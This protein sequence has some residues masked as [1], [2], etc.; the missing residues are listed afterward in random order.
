MCVCVYHLCLTL[1][2]SLSRSHITL[3]LD[4]APLSK[5]WCCVRKFIYFILAPFSIPCSILIVARRFLRFSFN[6]V[7]LSLFLSHS[8]FVSVCNPFCEMMQFSGAKC[9]SNSRNKFNFHWFRVTLRR[10]FFTQHTSSQA[11]PTSIIS[12]FFVFFLLRIVHFV[13]NFD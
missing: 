10:F 7:A 12:L 4:A 8:Q 11:L 9:S 3:P 5:V 6:S 13:H 2:L 1:S